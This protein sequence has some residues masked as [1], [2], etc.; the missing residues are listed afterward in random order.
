[1][2]I[3]RVFIVVVMDAGRIA[4]TGWVTNT[5]GIADIGWVTETGWVATG[6]EVTGHA[7]QGEEGLMV[8][9]ATVAA[10]V[11]LR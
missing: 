11:L 6:K 8:E 2:R 4:E 7:E 1:M 10:N 5:G 9:D 3:G